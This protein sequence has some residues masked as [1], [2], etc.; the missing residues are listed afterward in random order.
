MLLEKEK[1]RSYKSIVITKKHRDYKE[2]D[3]DLLRRKHRV[4]GRTL[5]PQNNM[6][7]IESL[8]GLNPYFRVLSICIPSVFSH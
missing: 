7:L 2:K 6:M 3:S 5:P 1:S 8:R 4:L